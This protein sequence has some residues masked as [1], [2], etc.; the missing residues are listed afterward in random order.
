MEYKVWGL[1]IG[2]GCL[3][4][5]FNFS[6]FLPRAQS[7][8]RAL[9]APLP[10]PLPL[11]LP[12]PHP[13]VLSSHVISHNLFAPFVIVSHTLFA[14][15]SHVVSHYHMR[16]RFRLQASASERRGNNLKR[17]VDFNMEV[18]A[19]IWCVCLERFGDGREYGTR[20][21]VKTRP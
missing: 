10:P 8:G 4:L 13:S 12:P 9:L 17:S 11:P 14:L 18:K 20:E 16:S 15:P 21:K 2:V 6:I 3:D 19:R 5:S 1:Y 7:C